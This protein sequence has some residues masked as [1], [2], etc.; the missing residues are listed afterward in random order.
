MMSNYCCIVWIVIKFKKY[1]KHVLFIK[2]KKQPLY[3]SLVILWTPH[4][5]GP[6][7]FSTAIITGYYLFGAESCL[8]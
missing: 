1:Y 2:D 6:V 7:A 5:G 4:I 3:I 8:I